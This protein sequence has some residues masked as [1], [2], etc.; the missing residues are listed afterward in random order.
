MQD[1][2]IQNLCERGQRELI[3]TDYLKAVDTLVIAE[4]AAWELRAFDTLSR[5]YLPLQEARRQVRQRCGEGAVR[6]RAF[7]TS[8]EQSLAASELLGDCPHGQ[9]L[10]A[11]WGTASPAIEFRQLAHERRLYAETFL[12]AAC[13]LADGK[14]AVVIV[15]LADSQLPYDNT[16]MRSLDELRRLMPRHSLLIP[17]EELPPDF[18]HGTAESYA[19]VM[20]LWERLHLPFLREA[21][22]E[23]E[24]IKKMQAYRRTLRV[25][26]A[27]ELAHQ[28]LADVARELG[29]QR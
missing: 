15:P 14:F 6:L 28:H 10:I 25:D 4:Q 24:P 17:P 22:E 18:P 9:L 20:G 2:E 21:D 27:C 11:G 23:P 5:L 8:P 13:P 29:R 19:I 1:S 16:A 26:P 3:E 7:T 12:G